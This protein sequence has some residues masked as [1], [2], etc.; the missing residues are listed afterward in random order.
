MKKLLFLIVLSFFVFNFLA[1]QNHIDTSVPQLKLNEG[2]HQLG[3]STNLRNT[4]RLSHRYAIKNNLAFRSSLNASFGSSVSNFNFRNVSLN[5]SVGLE[6]HNPFK[7]KWSFYYGVDAHLGGAL[8][9]F[10]NTANLGITGF[11]GVKF[12]PL[13]NISLFT[14]FGLGPGYRWTN[15]EFMGV[16]SSGVT[17]LGGP[18]FGALI[19]I[20]K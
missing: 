15:I 4:T 20:G 1:A 2:Q 17:I 8:S 14:E 10:G 11:A 16:V 7:E 6:K 18:Q 3:I 9:E 19:D 13:N 5:T 12:K